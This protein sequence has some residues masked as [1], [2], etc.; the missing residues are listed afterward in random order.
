MHCCSYNR[1]AS[2]RWNEKWD[3]VEYRRKYFLR[4]KKMYFTCQS[5]LLPSA[6]AVPMHHKQ[7]LLL[8]IRIP[9]D[10][11]LN[12]HLMLK[13]IWNYQRKKFKY[14][15][16]LRCL[17]IKIWCALILNPC[18]MHEFAICYLLHYYCL[19]SLSEIQ[20]IL[21]PLSAF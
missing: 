17:N 14:L 16:I 5:E 10:R 3:K 18:H 19:N 21:D 9:Y 6:I 2:G 15:C 20:N 1:F 11:S 8:W 12:K 13:Y 4:K 7:G